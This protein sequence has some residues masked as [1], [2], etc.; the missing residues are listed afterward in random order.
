MLRH[1]CGALQGLLRAGKGILK[2]AKEC[3]VGTATVQR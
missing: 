2:V 1:G 3:G